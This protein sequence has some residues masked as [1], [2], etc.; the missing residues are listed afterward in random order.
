MKVRR[1]PEQHARHCDRGRRGAKRR[2]RNARLEAA[3]Q[4]FQDEN[5]AG[6]RRVERGRKACA[7]AGRQKHS[8]VGPVAAEHLPD[9][10]GHGRAHLDARAL[11]TERK[12]RPD[13]Q[14]AADELDRNDAKRRLRQF[15]VQHRLDVRDAAPRRIGREAPNQRGRDESRS[16]ASADNDQ[17]AFKLFAVR[18][19]Y[20]GVPQAVRLL[21]REPEDR[22][23][24]S[25]R[26]AHNQRQECEH[27]K[28]A[29]AVGGAGRDI[30]PATHWGV[31]YD[32]A[33]KWRQSKRAPPRAWA[34]R[35]MRQAIEIQFEIR[36]RLT[37]FPRPDCTSL[38]LASLDDDKVSHHIGL[39][40]IGAF[41]GLVLERAGRP[42]LQAILV[43]ERRQRHSIELPPV[44]RQ[45]RA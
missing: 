38:R 4:F 37:A 32:A 20:Q 7:R 21:E 42:S 1:I 22:P 10:V 43:H 45:E 17:K 3:H 30:L 44:L 39:A 18:P 23:H 6:D 19:A 9:Q 41:D 12:P 36:I 14:H 2:D 34:P 16:R 31:E 29:G 13:R 11:T 40:P 25:R 5:G 28:I 26:R 35:Y 24:Q 15:P 33:P 8:A 27:E